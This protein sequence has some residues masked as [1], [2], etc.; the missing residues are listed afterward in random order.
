MKICSGSG[1]KRH[2]WANCQAKSMHWYRSIVCM[3][4]NFQFEIDFQLAILSCNLSVQI[5]KTKDRPNLMENVQTVWSVWFVW[6]ISEPEWKSE[7]K[8]QKIRR[9]GTIENGMTTEVKET[10]IRYLLRDTFSIG[11]NETTK[12]CS[13]L[14]Q[15]KTSAHRNMKKCGER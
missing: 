8:K 5:E 6:S 11:R 3:S 2:S 1:C 10:W 13:L 12:W 14:H 15:T 7:Q 4:I 9:N